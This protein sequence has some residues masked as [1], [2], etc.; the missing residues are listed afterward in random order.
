MEAAAVNRFVEIYQQL[1]KS[2]LGL[3]EEIY[4]DDVL[5]VDAMHRIEGLPTLR[6]YFESLYTNLEYC[7]FDIQG[8]Q[9]AE[10]TAWLNWQMCFV[11]PKLAGGKEITVDGAT[12]LHFEDKVTFHRDYMDAGQMLYEHIPLLG[13][14]IR[15][16]KNR[17]LT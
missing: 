11:H 12:N 14:A 8:V 5:F 3:I 13:G 4:A 6:N 16:I 9:T 10:S 15:Y 2:N 1:N 17:A 7:R